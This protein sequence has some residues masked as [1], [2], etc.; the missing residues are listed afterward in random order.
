MCFVCRQ[1]C[2]I[3]LSVVC[4]LQRCSILNRFDVQ[5]VLFLPLKITHCSS[6][7]NSLAMSTPVLDFLSAIQFVGQHHF[8]NLRQF[9]F[10]SNSIIHHH[11]HTTECVQFMGTIW[12]IVSIR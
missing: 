3:N 10:L 8:V 7:S 4:S 6:V 11:F 9:A 12:R 2:C 1:L 5:N